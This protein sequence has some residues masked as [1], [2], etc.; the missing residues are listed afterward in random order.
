M[1]INNILIII[2]I[3]FG[4]SGCTMKVGKPS[5]DKFK[6]TMDSLIYYYNPSIAPKY[7]S[8]C[9]IKKRY[10]QNLD[11]YIRKNESMCDK[12]IPPKCIFA[13]I[14]NKQNKKIINWKIISGKQFCKEQEIIGGGEII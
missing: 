14:V 8:K 7:L 3:L 11:I 10:S 5:Y 13:L 4:F 6:R 1:R 2:V 12:N 9:F